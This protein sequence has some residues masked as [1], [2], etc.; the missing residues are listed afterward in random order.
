M[1]PTFPSRRNRLGQLA[2]L[3]VGRQENTPACD[4]CRD[5]LP[6][7]VEAE[8]EG[9]AA[10]Q[11][12]PQVREHLEVCLACQQLY[13]DQLA[14]AQRE[15]DNQLPTLSRSPRFDLSFLPQGGPTLEQIVYKLTQRILQL[16]CPEQLAELELV[17]TRLLQSLGDLK[18]QFNSPLST[19]IPATALSFADQ[20]PSARWAVAT[21]FGLQQA[22]ATAASGG[23][24]RL[25]SAPE[26]NDLIYSLARTAARQAGLGR[27]DAGRFASAFVRACSEE[28]WEDLL[29]A[30]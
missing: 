2:R 3:I 27:Q 1:S 29:A 10:D 13:A 22:R 7:Y 20:I 26:A 9:Q 24:E 15:V 19:P 23:I 12:Y 30:P 11:L 5:L 6:A 21:L 4:Q 28:K 25:T 17:R 14:V 8:S 18:E 16:V